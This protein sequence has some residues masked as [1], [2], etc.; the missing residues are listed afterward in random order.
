MLLKTHFYQT[1]VQSLAMLVSDSLTHSLTDNHSRLVNLIDVTLACEDASQL[2][3]RL[4]TQ[5]KFTGSKIGAIFW[6]TISRVTTKD[7]KIG[8]LK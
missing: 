3:K 8:Q 7:L 6:Q 5:K 2:P 4:K 1:R